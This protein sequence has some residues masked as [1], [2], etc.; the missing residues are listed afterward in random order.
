MASAAR[1]SGGIVICQVDRIVEKNTLNARSVEVPGALID[2]IVVGAP[3][4][5]RQQYAIEKAYEPSWSGEI[6]IPLGDLERMP[7]N[8]RKVIARRAA[9]EIKEGDF[10][11]LGIGVPTGVSNVLNEEGLG[12]HVSLSIESGTVGGVQY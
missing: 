11:N 9:M 10:V 3:E 5:S 2:Y 7:L 1:N 4:N 6:R 12:D 8:V